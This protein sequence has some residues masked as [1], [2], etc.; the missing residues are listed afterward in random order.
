MGEWHKRL[1]PAK[2]LDTL[3]TP[4]KQQVEGGLSNVQ[5]ALI[6]LEIVTLKFSVE[7]VNFETKG[8]AL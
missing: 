3:W 5:N 8:G 6:F 4:G 1:S 2:N 7:K